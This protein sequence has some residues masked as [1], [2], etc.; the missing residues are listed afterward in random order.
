MLKKRFLIISLASVVSMVAATA[1][2][3][4]PASPPTSSEVSAE[5]PAPV[6]ETALPVVEGSGGGKVVS[7]TP[8]SDSDLAVQSPGQS[9]PG[10][11]ASGGP[12]T[13]PATQQ[14]QSQPGAS[15]IY[16]DATYKFAVAY[17]ADFVFR[18]LPAEKLAQLEPVPTASFALMN[19]TTAAS[20]LGD[21]EPADLE[22]RVYAAEQGV[23]L[24][25]WLTANKLAP[26]DGSVPLK[27]FKT[28]NVSGF[29]VCAS[30]MIIP[31][32]SY[33]VAGNGWV[34]QL[35]PVSIAGETMVETFRLIP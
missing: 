30:T 22:I 19:P 23:L 5:I 35:I 4:L 12:Q 25:S 16:T 13:T 33:V 10:A 6:V 1:C 24:D 8:M 34:Y 14:G 31:G 28:A 2:T 15:G 3:P 27:P 11:G 26:A 29:Q 7:A 18:T 17:P 20:D 32:C 21:L 9:Q